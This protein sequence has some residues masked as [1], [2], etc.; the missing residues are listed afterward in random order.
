[1]DRP[2]HHWIDA[3]APLADLDG[4]TRDAF[5][6]LR[7]R[8]APAGA[9]LFAPGSA[10]QGFVLVLSGRVRVDMTGRGGRTLLLYRVG[11]SETCVQTTLCMLGESFYTAEGVAETPIDFVVVPPPLFERA[12]ADSDA[13]RRFVFARFA[14]RLGEMMR[15]LETIAFVRVDAR[16]AAALCARAGEGAAASLA[17]T[18]QQLAED[19]GTAREVVSRQLE[20]FRRDGLVALRRGRIDILDR[21]GLESL[22]GVT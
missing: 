7:P 6:A 12:M 14:A 15:L 20:G 9:V 4:A 13:F 11:P 1:M 22:A 5:R 10:C 17:V 8:A 19:V 16:L 3:Y 2:T 21:P 18:H